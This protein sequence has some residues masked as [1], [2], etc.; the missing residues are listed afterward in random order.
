MPIRLFDR[1]TAG[2]I[3]VIENFEVNPVKTKVIC[4]VL[5]RIAPKGKVLIVDDP[6]SAE[7]RRAARNLARIVLQE[8]IKLNTLDLCK[9]GR[10]VVSTKALEKIISRANAANGGN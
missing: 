6:F 10:I 3:D 1:A 4:Q 5:T 7:T 2:D 8:A 9:Y